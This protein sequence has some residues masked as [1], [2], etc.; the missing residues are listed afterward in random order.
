LEVWTKDGERIL[1]MVLQD[2]ISRWR[3]N[4]N[5]LIFKSSR[6]SPLIYIAFLKERTITAIKHPYSEEEVDMVYFDNLLLVA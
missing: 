1:H 6:N 5:V 2:E 3:V 4:D